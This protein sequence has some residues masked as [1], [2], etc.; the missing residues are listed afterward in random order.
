MKIEKGNKGHATTH[1]SL[2]SGC[3]PIE[4]RTLD[5]YW[6]REMGKRRVDF[7]SVNVEGYELLVLKGGKEMFKANPP[8]MMY[9]EWAPDFLRD[10]N[11]RYNWQ[12]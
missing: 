4:M 8:K 7:L 3:I 5:D 10:N 9:L 12:Y 1:D 2:K 6:Q 11:V